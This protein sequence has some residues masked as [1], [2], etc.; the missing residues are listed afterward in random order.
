MNWTGN[1]RKISRTAYSFGGR[2]N[3]MAS[4]SCR[5][6]RFRLSCP[7]VGLIG[8]EQTSHLWWNTSADKNF[9]TADERQVIWTH[10]NGP[11]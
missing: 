7:A 10:L 1:S 6:Y 3:L 11:K 9:A 2:T 4:V 8:A 5:D